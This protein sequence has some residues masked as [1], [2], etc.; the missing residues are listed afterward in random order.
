MGATL[1]L[2]CLL[3]G[4]VPGQAFTMAR[5]KGPMLSHQLHGYQEAVMVVV[6]VLASRLLGYCCSGVFLNPGVPR[7]API[8]AP[9]V[10]LLLKRLFP[11]LNP[12]LLKIPRVVS[13]SRI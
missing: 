5:L 9:L 4:K 3:P 12:F 6:V 10:L 2:W 13:V 1:L 7:V 8:L 11:T